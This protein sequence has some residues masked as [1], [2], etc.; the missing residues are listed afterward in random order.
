MLNQR[1][2]LRC[3]LLAAT[4]SVAALCLTV[5]LARAADP[6][7]DAKL[8]QLLHSN[9]ATSYSRIATI[10][11]PGKPLTS[12]DFT[13]VDPVLPL[14]YLTDRSN[15]SL[16]IFDIRTNTLAA[17]I[18]GFIGTRNDPA[19]GLANPDISGPAS[20]LPTTVGEVWVADGDSTV[21]VV[22][23][24]SQKIVATISTA[25]PGQTADQAKRA[26]GMSYDP[27][28]QIMMVQNGAAS[29]PFVTIIS[30]RPSDRRVLGHVVFNDAEAV[31]ASVYDPA[32]GFFYVNLPQIGPDANNGA[33]SVVDPRKVTEVNRFPLTG[34]NGAGIALAPGQK[35]LIGCSLSVNSQIIS[36]RDGT[37]LAAIP[38]VSGS[39]QV[40]YNPGDG[41]F[42]LAARTNPATTGGPSLGI[43]NAATN[44][45][46][47]NV[48]TNVSAHAVSADR[49]TN[50]IFV[51]SGPIAGD[52]ACAAGCVGVYA[53]KE[54]EGRLEQDIEKLLGDLGTN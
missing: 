3:S 1:G 25:L 45:F 18:S 22:D 8:D 16:D 26:D 35:L 39:D 52:A 2:T 51:P 42:Y 12:F 54:H 10:Q 43:I 5:G 14:Y 17:R 32:N 9:E 15:A 6:A 19:T 48:P 23:L 29:P 37:L 13:S 53:G 38:Q 21:K 44:K 20:V 49:R 33:V 46:V 31:E 34:C 40:T 47:V 30:T 27:R 11:V 24:F 7:L 36:A 28:D 41:N 50:H 4:V